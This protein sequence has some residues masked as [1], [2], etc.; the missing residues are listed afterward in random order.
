MN[1]LALSHILTNTERRLRRVERQNR[2]LFVLLCGALAIASIAVSNAQPTVITAGEVRAQR[3]TLLDP[4][5]GM[6]DD[7]YS[8]ATRDGGASSHPTPPYSGWGFNGP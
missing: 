7:W 1:D 5:G 2:L 4:N 3:F 8:D 6:A